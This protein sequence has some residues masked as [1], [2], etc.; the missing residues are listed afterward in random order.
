MG[1]GS[2][3]D[4]KS[5]EL[6]SN[7][8]HRRWFFALG[9]ATF[10][11]LLGVR[12]F[13]FPWA[14]GQQLPSTLDIV[15]TTLDGFLVAIVTGMITAAVFSWLTPSEKE[16]A[17]IMIIQPGRELKRLLGDDLRGTRTFWYKGHTGK[18]TRSVTLPRLASEARATRSTKDIRIVIL[19]PNN[20]GPCRQLANFDAMRDPK[21]DTSSQVTYIKKQLLATVLAAYAWR[22]KEPLL[23]IAVGLHNEFSLFR[24][25]VTDQSAIVTRSS[26]RDLT[27]RYSS[28]SDFYTTF[29]EETRVSFDRSKRLREVDAHNFDFEHLT[30]KTARE[31]LTML[32]LDL[33]KILGSGE[34]AL[35]DII[36]IVR[37]EE[38]RYPD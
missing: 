30:E 19:D 28:R 9:V 23:Q 14:W 25:D 12:F 8:Y 5:S 34:D 13:I 24:I 15:N 33:A 38:S 32:E 31:L 22:G 1:T 17:E 7:P 18:W 16:M 36:K 10:V 6:L 4:M 37:E 21:I 27:V 3:R 2:I 35:A 26:P 29:C 11:A 20:D